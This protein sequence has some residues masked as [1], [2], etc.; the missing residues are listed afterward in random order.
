MVTLPA[1][2]QYS[3][4]DYWGTH[5]VAFN[6]DRGHE[7][8][9]DH[10][11][12]LVDTQQSAEP[13][14]CTWEDVADASMTMADHLSHNL[15]T[16]PGPELSAIARACAP[17]ARSKRPGA[18]W[19]PRTSRC[20]TCAGSPRCTPRPTR[21]TPTGRASARTSRTWRLALAK[22]VGLPSR[23]VSGYFH[24]EADAT[25]GEE[26][27]RGEP[28]LGGGVDGHVVGLRPDE[29]LPGRGAPR[30]R[31]AAGATT[32]TSHRSRASTPATPRTP[33]GSSCA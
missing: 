9:I 12:S 27:T 6:V 2:P 33:C 30:R 16:A 14:D 22:S 32:P 19:P 10:G 23:Y 8:L 18:S 7:V 5:V 20:A 31:R 25:I 29:R 4:I 1:A 11:N 28:R 3:Y 24:P 17:N 13:E 15:Y 26:I 21:R